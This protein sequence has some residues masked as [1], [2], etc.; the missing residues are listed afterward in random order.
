MNQHHRS[1]AEKDPKKVR[2]AGYFAGQLSEIMNLLPSDLPG[3]LRLRD[4]G[5]F[6]LGYFHQMNRRKDAEIAPEELTEKEKAA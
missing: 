2:L 3:T 6:A 1:K 4:Q 5:K